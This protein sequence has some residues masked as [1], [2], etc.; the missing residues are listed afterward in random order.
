MAEIKPGDR[1]V[2][3]VIE[4]WRRSRDQRLANEAHQRSNTTRLTLLVAQGLQR[5]AA[6]AGTPLADG[7]ALVKAERIVAG[8]VGEP[9][10]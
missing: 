9:S 3:T 6:D 1:L 8:L 4:G 10:A 2:D 5:E 7:A